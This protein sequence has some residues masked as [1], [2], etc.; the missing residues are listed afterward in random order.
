MTDEMIFLTA[1]GLKFSHPLEHLGRT[2][3]DLPVIAIDTFKHMYLWQYNP[4]T[5]IRYLIAIS[6]LLVSSQKHS[7]HKDSFISQ[8]QS[9]IHS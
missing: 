4:K 1:D 8:G 3:E 9:A 6:S 2:T 5:D 7:K